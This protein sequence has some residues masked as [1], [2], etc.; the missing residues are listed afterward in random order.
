MKINIVMDFFSFFFLIIFCFCF[1]VIEAKESYVLSKLCY[2]FNCQLYIFEKK[3][4]ERKAKHANNL[5]HHLELC[6]SI[7]KCI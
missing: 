3:K 4:K 6:N 7:Y 2:N 1:Q 5:T